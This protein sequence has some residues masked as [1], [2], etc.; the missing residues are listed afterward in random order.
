M[1]W[2]GIYHIPISSSLVEISMTT[3]RQFLVVLTMCMDAFVLVIETRCGALLLDFS[4]AF[5]L[6]IANSSF[7]QRRTT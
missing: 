3:L 2:C 5:E 4:K 6:V 1:R 7:C